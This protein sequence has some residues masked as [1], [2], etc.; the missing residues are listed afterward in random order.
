M[1]EKDTIRLLRECDAGIQM[2]ISAIE[3]VLPSTKNGNLRSALFEC[4]GEHLRLDKE[5]R[6]LLNEYGDKGKR[7]N[8]IVSGMSYMKTKAKLL[9]SEGDGT[10]ASIMTDGCNMGIKSLSRYLN[11]Y[12]RADERSRSIAKR[13]ISS[14]DELV[15]T[16]RSY[17]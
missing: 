8:P 14:E 13:L 11:E 6:T 15:K 1:I 16:V 9:V 2:G 12:K 10:V 7:P 3:E 17:L 5:L 4:R